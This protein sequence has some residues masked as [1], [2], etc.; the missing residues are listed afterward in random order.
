METFFFDLLESDFVLLS[1][2]VLPG[3]VLDEYSTIDV[4]LTGLAFAGEDVLIDT[5][6]LGYILVVFSSGLS[7]INVSP[8][9]IP[10]R[11][12]RR[13]RSVAYCSSKG[14]R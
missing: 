3:T 12:S 10:I 6:A 7:D 1:P 13:T 2:F 4:E 5:V 11:P 8:R 9:R 14:T